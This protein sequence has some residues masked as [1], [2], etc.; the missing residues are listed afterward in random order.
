LT[1]CIFS[2]FAPCLTTFCCIKLCCQVMQTFTALQQT[3]IMV[4][5]ILRGVFKSKQD[6]VNKT[7]I[8]TFRHKWFLHI[9]TA[10]ANN[11]FVSLWPSAVGGGQL[12]GGDGP[13]GPSPVAFEGVKVML[14]SCSSSLEREKVS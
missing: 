1:V 4:I 13:D 12:F 3:K 2:P 11:N 7:R 8:V 9:I 10:Y 5:M 6:Y 14:A